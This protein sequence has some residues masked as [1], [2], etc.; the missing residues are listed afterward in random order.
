VGSIEAGKKADFLLIDCGDYGEWPYHF[1]V[2]LVRAVFKEGECVL[3]G[4]QG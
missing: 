3:E 2:N 1:G 4:G